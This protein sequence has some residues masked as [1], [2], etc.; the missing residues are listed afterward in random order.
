MSESLAARTR[1]IASVPP[2]GG[3]GTMRRTCRVGQACARPARANTDAKVDPAKSETRRR[4]LIIA[5]SIASPMRQRQRIARI[6]RQQA[7]EAAGYG[8]AKQTGPASTTGLVRGPCL[9]ATE[10]DARPQ[11]GGPALTQSGRCDPNRAVRAL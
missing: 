5:A 10:A 2:P 6:A 11:G 1:E 9:H 8:R 3:N 7:R 4:R